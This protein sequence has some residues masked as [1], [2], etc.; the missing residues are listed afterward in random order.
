MSL[1]RCLSVLPPETRFTQLQINSQ[2]RKEFASDS[3]A[4][5]ATTC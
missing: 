3:E 4:R 2:E 1:R 5:F